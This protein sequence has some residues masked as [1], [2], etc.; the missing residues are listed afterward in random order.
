MERQR[1]SRYPLGKWSR[2]SWERTKLERPNWVTARGSWATGA[3][4]AAAFRPSC[5]SCHFGSDPQS[6][7]P[8]AA[9]CNDPRKYCCANQKWDRSDGNG[10]PNSI[11]RRRPHGTREAG[12]NV[13]KVSRADSFGKKE[14]QEVHLHGQSLYCCATGYSLESSSHGY[15]ARVYSKYRDAAILNATWI[16]I[17]N[18]ARVVAAGERLP[19]VEWDWME[20]EAHP[21]SGAKSLRPLRHWEEA[22]R[23][24]LRRDV[25]WK[26]TWS[27]RAILIGTTNTRL[28]IAVPFCDSF[29]LFV[30]VVVCTVTALQA[31]RGDS[32]YPSTQVWISD[33]GGRCRGDISS[34]RY[35]D[36]SAI[37]SSVSTNCAPTMQAVE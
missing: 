3:A 14:K 32:G 16:E 11:L 37:E 24:P 19:R 9:C 30:H 4:M 31:S 34:L 35:L 15:S 10:R 13:P 29:I 7:R 26:T 25:E 8:G 17:W 6:A 28:W 27:F 1:P 33:G 20:E 2:D 12:A 18:V 5:H 36:G 23:T 21:H 22:T